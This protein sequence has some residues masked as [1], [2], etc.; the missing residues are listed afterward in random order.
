MGMGGHRWHVRVRVLMH[1]CELFTPL[2]KTMESKETGNQA[3]RLRSIV[4]ELYREGG[5]PNFY[6]GVAPRMINV[7]LWGTVMVSVYEFL[8]RSSVKS[9]PMATTS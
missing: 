8:K 9:A 2:N 7:A 4:Q 1:L 6:R 3:P 5:V